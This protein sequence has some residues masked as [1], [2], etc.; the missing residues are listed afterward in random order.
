MREGVSGAIV[1]I[2]TD[3]SMRG[4]AG[5]RILVFL[6]AV[7]M[8]VA[9]GLCDNTLRGKLKPVVKV[10]KD[11]ISVA[12]AEPFDTIVAPAA[13]LVRLSGYDK[14]LRSSAETMFV[15]NRLDKEILQLSIKIVY[16]DMSGRQLHE[17]DIEIRTGIPPGAT[18]QVR[19]KSWDTQKSFYYYRGQKPKVNSVSPYDVKCTVN[20]CVIE[21]TKF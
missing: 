17:R 9:E 4:I 20:S 10:A 6:F 8:V 16:T 5:G 13:A 19:I 11:T 2:R 7:A 3:I 14:P 15:T 18:R 21:S 1:A 12:S